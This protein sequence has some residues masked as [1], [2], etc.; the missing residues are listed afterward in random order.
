MITLGADG[1]KPLNELVLLVFVLWS[2]HLQGTSDRLSRLRM[3]ETQ[4]R[5]S[6]SVVTQTGL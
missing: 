1:I 5:R 6:G 3:T 4:S 2:Y